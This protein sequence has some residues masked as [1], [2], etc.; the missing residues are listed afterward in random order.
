MLNYQK[1]KDII[2]SIQFLL[3]HT[4]KLFLFSKNLKEEKSIIFPLC[5]NISKDSRLLI[6]K[7]HA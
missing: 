6:L 5:K 3:E 2:W 7:L 4:T 1:K